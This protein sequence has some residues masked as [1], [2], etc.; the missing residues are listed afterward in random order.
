MEHVRYSRMV[1]RCGLLV[2][3]VGCPVVQGAVARVGKRRSSQPS[4][5]SCCFLSGPYLL[6]WQTFNSGVL[7]LS[8]LIQCQLSKFS[9]FRSSFCPGRFQLIQSF[10]SS[11]LSRPRDRNTRQPL[12]AKRPVLSGTGS[13]TSSR[14]C[15]FFSFEA[16]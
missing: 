2:R 8:M 16:W 3:H 9:H 6:S 13:S 11:Q 10:L 4:E 15:L 7:I 5:T 12:G 14:R 1:D